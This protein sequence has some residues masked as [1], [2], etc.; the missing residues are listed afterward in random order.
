[1]K[2]AHEEIKHKSVNDL[3]NFFNSVFTSVTQH[4][5][6][7]S[8]ADLNYWL[9]STNKEQRER[10]GE[11]RGRGG[12]VHRRNTKYGIELKR[13]CDIGRRILKGVGRGQWRVD[14]TKTHFVHVWTSPQQERYYIKPDEYPILIILK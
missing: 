7:K 13:R 10:G 14:I 1:M 3:R 8:C 4:R 11:G 5:K 2:S 9:R 12:A 6:K